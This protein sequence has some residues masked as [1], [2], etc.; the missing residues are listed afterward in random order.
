MVK[1]YLMRAM[2]ALARRPRLTLIAALALAL[3]VGANTAIFSTVDRAL[4]KSPR[5]EDGDSL[6][7][8]ADKSADERRADLA[9]YRVLPF[10]LNQEHQANRHYVKADPRDYFSLLSVTA[11]ISRAVAQS[12]D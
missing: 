7:R 11:V 1:Q 8:Q 9:C 6:M 2:E 3:G 4:V 12:D 10:S 5:A